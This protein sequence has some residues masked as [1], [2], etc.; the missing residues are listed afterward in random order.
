MKTADWYNE[1]N[2]LSLIKHALTNKTVD[3][4]NQRAARIHQPRHIGKHVL[5]VSW[6]EK[7]WNE[8]LGLREG[9]SNLKQ[10]ELVLLVQFILQFLLLIYHL[11]IE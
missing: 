4:L 7:G 1:L 5:L 9:V 3:Q 6:L 8:G 2:R 11:L 10:V